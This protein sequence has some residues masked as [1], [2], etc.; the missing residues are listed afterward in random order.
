[1]KTKIIKSSILFLGLLFIGSL[2][3]NAQSIKPQD[4]TILYENNLRACLQV[5]LDPEP[6]TLKM[7]WK[8]Y[9]EDNYN[10]KL[11]GISRFHNKDILYAENVKIDKISPY[12]MN[13]YTQ[14]LENE[15]GSEMKVFAS[16]GIDEFFDNANKPTEYKLM[17]EILE[18]FLKVYLPIYYTEEVND[19]KK[20]VSD[21]TV[22]INKLNDD[23]I[24]DHG[25]METLKRDIEELT[26]KTEMNETALELNKKKLI[27]REEKLIRIKKQ[28]NNL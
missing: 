16:Y 4:G 27:T 7:A 8:E 5:S 12:G 19:T 28:L 13:F 22:E 18:S 21:L 23:I 1:M 9:L 26:K 3:L 11:E 6:K 20:R 10:F 17:N 24:K 15:N 25:K 2:G 14:I